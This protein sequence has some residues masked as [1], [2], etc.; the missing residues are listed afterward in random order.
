[1]RPIGCCVGLIW[2][3]EIL[4]GF[5][6]E[7]QGW[8]FT[9]GKPEDGERMLQAAVRECREETDLVISESSLEFIGYS[10]ADTRFLVLIFVYVVPDVASRPEPRLMEPD[11]CAEW[12][13][14][15]IDILATMEGFTPSGKIAADML[16]D[17]LVRENYLPDPE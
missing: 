14:V 9:G 10:D 5:N 2:R 1:M 4:L 12:R 3:R 13:W 17:K 16:F 15:P 11:K 6:T 7:R 8:E